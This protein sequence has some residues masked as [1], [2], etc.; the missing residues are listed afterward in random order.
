MNGIRLFLQNGCRFAEPF[1]KCTGI[2]P[3][4]YRKIAR[5]E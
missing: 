4:E 2:L 5:R 1:K 3:I